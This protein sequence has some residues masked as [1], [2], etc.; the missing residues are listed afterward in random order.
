MN[1]SDQYEEEIRTR[2]RF[3][4]WI[5]DLGN[6]NVQIKWVVPWL[7]F[8]LVGLGLV[9]RTLDAENDR[10][11]AAQGAVE[12]A[13]I[14]EVKVRAY[15]VCLA[16][17]DGR[18]DQRKQWNAF[19]DALIVVYQENPRAQELINT[20]LRPQL[21]VNIPQLV[22]GDVCTPIDEPVPLPPAGDD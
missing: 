17:V 21:D 8:T 20:V 14:L 11:L 19:F 1:E 16:R 15:E 7:I 9:W 22:V 2:V 18:A 13:A 3:R 10:A 12:R 6:R 5:V 4:G